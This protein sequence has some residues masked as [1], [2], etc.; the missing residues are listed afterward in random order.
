MK[1]EKAEK[2]RE[3]QIEKKAA[4]QDKKEPKKK[5][6][7]AGESVTGGR[8]AAEKA[9][10]RAPGARKTRSKKNASTKS[11]VISNVDKVPMPEENMPE[12]NMPEEVIPTIAVR[13]RKMKRF[14]KATSKMQKLSHSDDQNDQDAD[15]QASV[16]EE[17]APKKKKQSR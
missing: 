7:K 12:E 6:K 10:E 11:P 14:R 9:R 3:K 2:R 16:P 8:T 1:K 5:A 17:L 4:K 15:D 13:S